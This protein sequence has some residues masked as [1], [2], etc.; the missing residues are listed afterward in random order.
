MKNE[1]RMTALEAEIAAK[2]AELHALAKEV[3]PGL[4]HLEA[5]AL[6][7]AGQKEP[8]SVLWSVAAWGAFHE[9]YQPDF[10]FALERLPHN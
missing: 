5:T 6:A 4:L 8:V 2:L 10:C 1:E 7:P 9:A 3:R